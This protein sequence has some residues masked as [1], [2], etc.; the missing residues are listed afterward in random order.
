MP[1]TIRGDEPIKN[2]EHDLLGRASLAKVI[3]GEVRNIDATEGFVVGI[4]GPW[5]SGKTSLVNLVRE[6]LA[7]EPIL[8]VLEFNPWMFSGS[9]QLIESFFVELS[10]QLRIVPGKMEK[11]ADALG[12]YGEVF[13]SLG[14]VPLVGTGFSIFGSASKALDSHYKNKK[15][16]SAETRNKLANELRQLAHP[17]VV[18]I[19]DI[20]RLQ[21]DEIRDI[22]KLVRLTANLPNIVYIVSFDRIRVEQ[23]LT[24]AGLPGRDYLEKIIQVA[25]DIPTIPP[26]MLDQQI[27]SAI[28]EALSEVPN[29][30]P[31][32]E[33]RWHRVFREIIFPLFRNMRDVRRYAASLPGTVRSLEGRV[34]LVDVLA[35]EAI[36]V[37]MPDLFTAIIRSQQALTVADDRT[38]F[39]GLNVQDEKLQVEEYLKAAGEQ[40]QL[41]MELIEQ[42][43]PS[44]VRHLRDESYGSSWLGE[45]TR[46]KRVARR[47]YLKLYL[48]RVAGDSLKALWLAER[49][50]AVSADPGELE[51]FFKNLDAAQWEDVIRAMEFYEGDL[52]ND[53]VVPMIVALLNL[54]PKIPERSRGI[55]ELNPRTSIRGIVYRLLSQL[56]STDDAE[57]AVRAALPLIETIAGRLELLD[58]IKST[59]GR[60]PPIISESTQ[61]ELELDLRN[62]VR[63]TPPGDLSQEP[64]VMWLLSWSK[65]T[66]QEGEESFELPRIE[67]I[68]CS[69]LRGAVIVTRTWSD[70]PAK[71]EKSLNWDELLELVGS[72]DAIGRIIELCREHV[73]DQSLSD[74]VELAQKY[75]DGWRPTFP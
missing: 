23:A 63:A 69:L 74:A 24:D 4:L 10:A 67:D 48:E 68:G 16:G 61:A 22:F 26:A 1:S 5:G 40:K 25:Y 58:T 65:Q 72:E 43:F 15:K 46:Q 41:A 38:V 56:S 39:D 70:G 21:T 45:W 33:K 47:D 3:A 8:A 12:A 27:I 66:T 52:P 75:L 29:R 50:I 55:F 30:G 59:H 44:A 53:A 60:E 6:E 20:D 36:R 37:F 9:D 73:D 71:V 18:V 19:D 28:N 64:G 31:F 7:K 54:M 17:L 32:D 49:A 13:A 34:S 2:A 62:E 42:L 11:I 35:L 57:Q 14:S 51:D